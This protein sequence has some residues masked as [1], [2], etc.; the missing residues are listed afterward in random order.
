MPAER[1]YFPGDF[2]LQT[3]IEFFDQEFH[4]LAHVMRGKLGDQIEIVNGNG[5][6]GQAIIT[7]LTKKNAS[8][9]IIE[10]HSENKPSHNII[11][12]QAMP[13]L[14]RLD[15]IVEKG[16][17]L[18]M[19]ELWLFPGHRSER[20][21]LTASLIE[22]M[23]SVSIA[24]MKQCGRLFL[25]AIELKPSLEKWPV[26]TDS[27][28]F[29]DISPE[30][31]S[32]LKVWKECENLIF[33]T[34]PESGFSQQEESLIKQWGGTGVK[35]HSNILRTDTASLAALSIIQQLIFN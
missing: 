29:G 21:A 1:F 33:F 22:R 32:L 35:L 23:K 28:F 24:A 18:G 30:A 14:N 31:P 5:F 12:A 15:F 27:I 13:K 4:H 3:K 9:E 34:G 2:S 7:S 8:L 11:L 20:K 19:S 17:E 25:P 10:I 6:L 26:L 16:T